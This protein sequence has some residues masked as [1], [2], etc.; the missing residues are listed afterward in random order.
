VRKY[1][2]ARRGMHAWMGTASLLR[3]AFSLMTQDDSAS[4]VEPCTLPPLARAFFS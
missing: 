4:W 2:G 3:A 1:A